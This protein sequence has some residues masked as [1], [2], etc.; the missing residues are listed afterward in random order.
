MIATVH[1]NKLRMGEFIQFLTNITEICRHDDHTALNI[2]TRLAPLEDSIDKLNSMF[3]KAQGS[4]LT[5]EIVA[6]DNRRDNA[7]ILLT[8]IARG[9]SRYSAEE[10]KRKAAKKIYKLITRHGKIIYRLNYQAET[11]TISSLV[12][13]LLSEPGMAAAVTTLGVQSEVDELKTSN[14]QFGVKFLERAGEKADRPAENPTELRKIAMNQYRRLIKQIEAL[15]VISG[16]EKYE[17]LIKELNTLIE[18]Y[19]REAHY[20]TINKDTKDKGEE[21]T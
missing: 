17:S 8:M 1:Y 20:R 16:P 12:N 6:L 11:S 7:L 15:A 9:Y 14:E 2:D 3:R 19:N 13:K 10:A 18:K 4:A 5:K 21:A